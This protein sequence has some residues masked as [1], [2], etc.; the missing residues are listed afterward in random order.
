MW[1]NGSV[2]VCAG[3]LSPCDPRNGYTS[4]DGKLIDG[5]GGEGLVQGQQCDTSGHVRLGGQMSW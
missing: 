3:Q 1:V 4:G 2:C 5:D